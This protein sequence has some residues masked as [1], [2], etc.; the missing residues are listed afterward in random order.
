MARFP[1]YDADVSGLPPTVVG[2]LIAGGAAVIGFGASA[3]NTRVTLRAGRQATR[4]Q[5]FWEKKTALYEDLSRVLDFDLASFTED[6]VASLTA[7]LAAMKSRVWLYASV[8][9][10]DHYGSVL[11][12]IDRLN[13]VAR[14]AWDVRWGSDIIEGKD[15][16]LLEIRADLLDSSVSEMFHRPGRG[17]LRRR[18]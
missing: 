15:Q 1:G 17:L 16:L 8:D 7:E 10:W 12:R 4:D 18:R 11:I 13:G 14:D 6:K 9:I 2:A 3:W 5:R